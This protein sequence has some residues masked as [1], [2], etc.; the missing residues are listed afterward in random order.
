MSAG[1][2]AVADQGLV[3]DLIRHSL[4]R[5]LVSGVPNMGHVS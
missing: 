4:M 3:V 5:L 2:A 1:S